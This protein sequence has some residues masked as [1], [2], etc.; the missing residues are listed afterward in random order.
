MVSDVPAAFAVLLILVPPALRWWWGRSLARAADDPLLPERL[1]ASGRR[2]GAVFG[3]CAATIVVVW[4]SL[5][6]WAVPLLI[7]LYAI[8]GF[9][10]RQTLYQ[11]TWTLPAYLGYLARLT[12]GAFG[13]WILLTATPWLIAAA[14][15]AWWIAALALA[16][17]LFFWNYHYGPIFRRILGT[18]PIADSVLAA[19][20]EALVVTAGIA[21]PRFEYLALDGGVVANAV[22]L[23]SLSGS[24]VVFSETLL[25]RLTTDE[26][27]AIAAHEVA[28]LEHYDRARLRRM[29]TASLALVAIAVAFAPLLQ[30]ATG[31]SFA[32]W[33]YIWPCAIVAALAVRAHQRQ[34]HETASDLR[35]VALTGDADALARA[36]VKLYA[37]ARIP[38]RWD[39]HF[40]QHATH[41]SLAR[42]IRDIRATQSTPPAVLDAPVTFAEA[43]GPA[44]ATFDA[45]GVSWSRT[46][47]ITQV[48]EY[49]ALVELR[50]D[51][52]FRGGVSLVAVDRAG[53][54]WKMTPQAADVPA[55]QAVLDRVDGRI[56]H[57]APLGMPFSPTVAR[58][59]AFVAAGCACV[60]GQVAFAFAA[61]LGAL[62][63]SPIFLNAAGAAGLA[64]A[65]WQIV[66]GQPGSLAH[67][68]ASL[69][70]LLGAALLT[71]GW[72]R[73]RE[74][75]PGQGVLR[76][77]LAAAAVLALLWVAAGG[78]APVRFHQSVHATPGVFALV[79]ATAAAAFTDRTRRAFRV[80][81]AAGAVAA[82]AILASGTHW[83]LVTFGSDPFLVDA[84]RASVTL[85]REA[86]FAEFDIPFGVQLV[87][88]SPG[89]RLAAVVREEDEDTRGDET[90]RVYHVAGLIRD[91]LPVQAD[92]L[93]FEDEARALVLQRVNG[94]LEL[95]DIHVA[96]GAIVWRQ[97][98]PAVK[99][100]TL[101]YVSASRAWTVTG[102]DERNRLVQTTG[103]AGQPAV[104]TF[105]APL[106]EENGWIES[107]ATDGRSAIAVQ[108]EIER[109]L[110]SSR[111]LLWS[112]LFRSQMWSHSQLW[113]LYGGTRRPIARTLLDTRCVNDIGD[114]GRLLC[115]AFDGEQT[116]IVAVG[117]EGAPHPIASIDGRFYPDE[118]AAAGWLTGWAGSAPVAVRLDGPE[119]VRVRDADGARPFT[120]AMT[121]TALGA[122]STSGSGTQ[123]R[124]YPLR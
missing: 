72:V 3:A 53:Q 119:V 14:G 102:R 6:W 30:A 27:V 94:Q 71:F 9:P 118:S 122:V 47:G 114:A 116:R 76:V 16:P 96:S 97:P 2:T 113:H 124:V 63:P 36:L 21:P 59:V 112:A 4:P 35:A 68:A 7:T 56:T 28:H 66:N 107:W 89:G 115:A 11:E 78:I 18:R 100:G 1:L 92:D 95:R 104:R 62:S 52:A 61:L 98:L 120:L 42:R 20:F 70:G 10:L 55:L 93:A 88:L 5:G 31:P 25:A 24:A 69:W 50:L 13:F 77:A 19:R 38:R 40:E 51:T 101:T 65:L 105:V 23:P 83:F 81:A 15:H 12:A 8:A 54:R 29:A 39:Q 82:I 41:P 79:A 48:T 17:A 44:T 60:L 49:A 90:S 43:G 80:E 75:A 32:E 108:K 123:I 86:P 57:A 33:L 85:L 103:T 64:A 67:S 73:R 45:S 26:I 58:L 99:W 117:T 46:A 74:R 110:V 37:I 91:L 106:P 34:Q 121:G 111:W 84:P 109:G 22:A 87:R